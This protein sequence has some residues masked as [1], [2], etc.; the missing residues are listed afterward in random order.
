MATLQLPAC[1]AQQAPPLLQRCKG[2]L[3]SELQWRQLWTVLGDEPAMAGA[4]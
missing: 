3:G 4:G 1:V 2:E